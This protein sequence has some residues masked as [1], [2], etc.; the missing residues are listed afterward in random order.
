[1]KRKPIVWI[2]KEQVRRTQAGIEAMDYTPAMKWGEPR[3]ITSFDPPALLTKSTVLEGWHKSVRAFIDAFDAETDFII[4]TGNP[5][6][7]MMIAYLMG[8]ARPYSPPRFLLWR[9][10]D[11]AYVPYN[12]LNQQ[13]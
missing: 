6:A 3:F 7:M 5:T 12:P 4:A 1:L 13:E 9:R 8:A 11:N 2:V 10:E